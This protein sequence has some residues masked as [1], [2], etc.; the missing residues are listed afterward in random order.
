MNCIFLGVYLG[1]CYTSSSSLLQGIRRMLCHTSFLFFS[2]VDKMNYNSICNHFQSNACKCCLPLLLPPLFLSIFSFSFPSLSLSLLLSPCEQH[3]QQFWAAHCATFPVAAAKIDCDCSWHRQ[4]GR[5]FVPAVGV[6][7]AQNKYI[8]KN[9]NNKNSKRNGSN[10][11]LKFLWG[12][13]GRMSFFDCY[14]DWWA[15]A[16]ARQVS[17]IFALSFILAVFSLS[18]HSSTAG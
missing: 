11:Q 16:A 17:D 12:T 18:F 1:A 14:A 10:K 4:I 9:N 13:T 2:A 15:S 7:A 8:H 5:W 3:M 6:P